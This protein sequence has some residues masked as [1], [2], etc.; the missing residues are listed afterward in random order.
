MTNKEILQ[1]RGP[2]LNETKWGMLSGPVTLP[3]DWV[4]VYIGP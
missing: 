4:V 1:L 3:E 2:V